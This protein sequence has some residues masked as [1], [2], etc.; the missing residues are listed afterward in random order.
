M[1]IQPPKSPCFIRLRLKVYLPSQVLQTN[2][3]FYHSVPTSQ[4]CQK[5]INSG[6]PLLLG[7]YPRSTL[8]RTLPPPSR[9]SVHFPLFAVIE[10]TFLQK[11]RSGTRRASPVARYVLVTVLSL[12][13]RQ[14]TKP[15]QLVFGHVCCLHPTDA[16]ST[17]GD[18]HFR[19]HL[20]VHFHYGP[21]T[22]S[23][24]LR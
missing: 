16:D 8:I 24:S 14:S 6:A 1:N 2:G 22:R 3:R 17:S 5:I 7:S 15:Y 9:L 19:G 12:P 11:F 18:F 13:P 21:M 10:P 4:C 23:P 20:C